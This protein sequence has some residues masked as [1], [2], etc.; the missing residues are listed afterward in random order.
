[1]VAQRGP[2]KAG[3]GNGGR[4]CVLIARGGRGRSGEGG[5]VE[6]GGIA[7]ERGQ[8][9]GEGFD[10]GLEP[11]GA[12]GQLGVGQVVDATR[13][14]LQG[15]GEFELVDL[16]GGGRWRLRVGAWRWAPRVRLL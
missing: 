3:G 15:V 7:G 16:R 4:G 10:L 2:H 5:A 6:G 11:G 13:A 1:M 9:F 8:R 12:V 14:T